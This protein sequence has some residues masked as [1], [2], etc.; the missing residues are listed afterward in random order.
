MA[1]PVKLPV[2]L[3][4]RSSA[5]MMFSLQTFMVPTPISVPPELRP[6]RPVRSELPEKFLRSLVIINDMCA[7]AY[8][9][10]IYTQYT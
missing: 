7:S 5:I 4:R 9:H 10:Q 8:G 1:R 2:L 3:E 6:V